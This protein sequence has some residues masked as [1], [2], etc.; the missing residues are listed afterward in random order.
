[1]K[2]KNIIWSVLLLNIMG[3]NNQTKIS[4][5][6]L[7]DSTMS[8]NNTIELKVSSKQEKIEVSSYIV[9]GD[10][11]WV[12]SGDQFL[13][14][15]L[16]VHKTIG[17]LSTIFPFMNKKQLLNNDVVLNNLYFNRSSIVTVL[18][19]ND[20]GNIEVVYV[21]IS[22]SDIALVNGIKVGLN[23]SEFMNYLSISLQK[24]EWD[25]IN[26]VILESELLG[27]WNYYYFSSVKLILK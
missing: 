3:C 15:P 18:D 2:Y 13:Y 9:K 10:T 24:S 11:L 19:M 12:V 1:M 6:Y 5:K 4:T 7:N 21:K 27:V 17:E 14:Y 26:I 8:L 22:D 25:K 16:G 20:S 23:K